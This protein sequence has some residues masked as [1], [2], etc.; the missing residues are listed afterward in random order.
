MCACM[1]VYEC[2]TRPL[3][4]CAALH[5]LE[6][7]FLFLH[8][9]ACPE[10]LQLVTVLPLF[11]PRGGWGGGPSCARGGK[12]IKPQDNPWDFIKPPFKVSSAPGRQGNWGRNLCHWRRG[13][14][15]GEAEEDSSSSDLWF[16]LLNREGG[17]GGKGGRCCLG[18]H[19][20]AGGVCGDAHIECCR[21]G[22]SYGF[23]KNPFH[24]V[25]KH[26]RRHCL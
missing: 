18:Y 19:R 5:F 4:T 2:H 12:V 7:S 21:S 25:T 6:F 10:A 3:E 15:R 23:L 11:W 8:S 9:L 24:S 14:W 20:C 22:A 1:C 13:R 26:R 17:T 16:P